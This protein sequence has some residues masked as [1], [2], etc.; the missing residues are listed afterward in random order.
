[1]S[2]VP[3]IGGSL[4]ASSDYQEYL[5]RLGAQR[6]ATRGSDS[7]HQLRTFDSEID[8]D[9]DGSSGQ[10]ETA[11]GEDESPEAEPH[12]DRDGRSGHGLSG[13]A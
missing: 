5:A 1:M 13:R 2:H 11:S 9:K 8:P 12:E 7:V 3:L 10:D 4:I 6:R